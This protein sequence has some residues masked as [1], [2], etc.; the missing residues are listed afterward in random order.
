[1]HATYSFTAA[2]A[3]ACA[4]ACSAQEAPTPATATA[5]APFAAAEAK[6]A[7]ALL[8]TTLDENFVFPDKGKAY[9]QALRAKLASG[10]Y[11]D[12][13]SSKAFAEAV[14]ADLQAV[15]PDRHLKLFAPDTEKS[16][17][18]RRGRDGQPPISKSGWLAPGVAYIAF[19]VF[20][21]D[22]E[23]LGQLRTFLS[24]H[25]EAKTLIID[26]REHR[27]G[28]LAEMDILFPYLFA[29]ETELVEMDTRL[30]VVE[31]GGALFEDGPTMRP[32][33]GPAGVVRRAHFAVP[34]EKATPLRDAKVFLLTSPRTASAAEHLSLSLKRTDRATL[35]GETTRGAGNYG[36]RASLP[37]GYS[38][39]IPIGRTF[40]PK[41]DTGWE[42]TGVEPDIKVPAADALDEAL[43]R[44]G[45]VQS[46]ADALAAID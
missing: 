21:G 16:G 27:G 13:A 34:A 2:L 38:A 40:D 24:S 20:P 29:K 4:S 35:I 6:E 42:G 22:P 9:A 19:S 32:V 15:Y 43:K 7:V 14:T 26:V 30:A 36:S 25:A 37:G 39:F 28:G 17:P 5:A 33:N 10:G 8:A 46:G 41:T 45:I 11:D 44:S 12:F 18:P 23:T 3:L 1:M 31:R